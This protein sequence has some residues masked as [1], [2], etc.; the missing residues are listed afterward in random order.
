MKLFKWSIYTAA[1]A[2]IAGTLV[3][4][5]GVTSTSTAEAPEAPDNTSVQTLTIPE[6][7]EPQKLDR[8]NYSV[9]VIPKP[10]PTPEPEP[11]PEVE[12]R[13]AYVPPHVTPDPGSAQAIAHEMVIARGWS[14]DDFA[15]LVSLW[16]RESG[17]NVNAHNTSSGA[18]G[19]PQSLPG[20]KMAS[21]GADWETNPV[22]QITWGLNYIGGRYGNPCGA[23]NASENQG[24][25]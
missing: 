14:E 8:G 16:N 4:V 13:Q 6:D 17:W 25:Y 9:E 21:V 3:I 5:P 2:V 20:N 15:C 24:W 11:E 19:I 10:T 1:V 23:W 22:T 18:Y 7:V 12:E